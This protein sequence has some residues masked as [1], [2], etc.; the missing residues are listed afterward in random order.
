MLSIETKILRP[1]AD[2]LKGIAVEQAYQLGNDG[3]H[4]K[5]TAGNLEI[6]ADSREMNILFSNV[7]I[8]DVFKG[9]I[10][11]LINAKKLNHLV[12]TSTSEYVKFTPQGE[13][14]TGGQGSM[15]IETNS[16]V[17]MPVYDCS[18][19]NKHE[20]I[21]TRP[22]KRNQDEYAPLIEQMELL[23]RFAGTGFSTMELT[24]ICSGKIDDT[25]IW[26]ARDRVKGVWLEAKVLAEKKLVI[27][28]KLVPLL[29]RMKS[30]TIISW[31]TK[32]RILFQNKTGNYNYQISAKVLDINYPLKQTHNFLMSLALQPSITIEANTKNMV[33]VFKRLKGFLTDESHKVDMKIR[34]DGYVE[35]TTGN[36]I[37]GGVIEEKIKITG[38]FTEDI[39][40][41]INHDDLDLFLRALSEN[42]TFK[43][44]IP[45]ND[46]GRILTSIGNKFKQSDKTWSFF[47]TPFGE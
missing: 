34:K 44:N 2:I 5:V 8:P 13:N 14:P 27:S 39:S 15:N 47:M 24:G 29:K 32:D 42:E 19:F 25:Y 38:D 7:S 36:S 21:N 10:E 16:L 41:A 26:I 1:I 43:L 45:L 46:S 9:N 23:E 6:S 37:S 12:S 28:P 22:E 20:W 11:F 18:I 31:I 3:I 33:E 35:F 40:I 17:N 4:F 30:E